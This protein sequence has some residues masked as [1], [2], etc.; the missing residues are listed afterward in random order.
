MAVV[1]T[2][3]LQELIDFGLPEG[4]NYSAFRIDGRNLL[5]PDARQQW[6]RKF[7]DALADLDEVLGAKSPYLNRVS[8]DSFK[9]NRAIVRLFRDHI[10]SLLNPINL[11][12]IVSTPIDMALD[13]NALLK[14]ATV[15][16]QDSADATFR[17]VLRESLIRSYRDPAK[18]KYHSIFNRLAIRQSA[19]R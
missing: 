12:R 8:G 17:F 9:R 6:R 4:L 18:A 2:S 19:R 16:M 13:K 11:Q 7:R 3:K 10:K 15:T 1:R 5:D 14:M